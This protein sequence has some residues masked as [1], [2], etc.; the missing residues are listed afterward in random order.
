MVAPRKTRATS[1]HV[2]ETWLV[3]PGPLAKLRLPPGPAPCLY[4]GKP[5]VVDCGERRECKIGGPAAVVAAL[6][7]AVSLT[8][9]SSAPNRQSLASQTP[10]ARA[11][12]PPPHK[13]NLQRPA[14]R[15]IPPMPVLLGSPSRRRSCS[16]ATAGM[17]VIPR[18]LASQSK[19][20]LMMLPLSLNASLDATV[21]PSRRALTAC[22]VSGCAEDDEPSELP[23]SRLAS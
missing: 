4:E 15:E 14:Y 6:A 2:T 11:A 10:A 3:P 20:G 5:P 12:S 19:D 18:N 23:A 16:T 7:D 8:R 9:S 17:Q 1:R 21:E 13:T 22:N